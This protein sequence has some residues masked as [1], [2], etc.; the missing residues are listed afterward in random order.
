MR[1]PDH[2]LADAEARGVISAEQRRQ[3]VD[4]F[5]GQAQAASPLGELDLPADEGPYQP[6]EA[7]EAPRFVRGFHDVLITIGIVAALGGLWGLAPL[8]VGFANGAIE[9]LVAT[10]VLAE[11]LVYR[12]RLAL[13]A[14]ALT[15]AYVASAATIAV[16]LAA[17]LLE[18][19]GDSAVA[20]LVF[21]ALPLIL[22]PYYWRYR[23]PVALA[24]MIGVA[25]LFVFSFAA[26]FLEGAYGGRQALAAAGPLLGFVALAAALGLFATAMAFDLRDPRRVTRRSDVAF[27]LH[28][29]AAPALLFAGFSLT[30]GWQG[31]LWWANEPGAREAATAVVLVAILMA[32]GIVIDRRAF[33]TAGLISLGV[34]IYTLVWKA[35]LEFSSLAAFALFAVGVI[36]LM[37]GTGWRVLR[38]MALSQVPVAMRERLPAA[39]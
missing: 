28:L 35:G 11:F 7:S 8:R 13:P 16:P 21:V 20:S 17:G 1:S 36:V 25:F 26:M 4:L 37:L 38:R 34:A 19:A 39:V 30:L 5:S 24:A 9:V 27:W 15:V 31:R 32:I 18:G 23:V 14:F 2:V 12:Q 3:L 22:A 6:E 29:F 10:I 33:V